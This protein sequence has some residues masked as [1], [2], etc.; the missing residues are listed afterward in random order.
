MSTPRDNNHT[1]SHFIN[2]IE[3]LDFIGTEPKLNFSMKKRNL[4]IWGGLLCI[5]IY[6]LMLIGTLYFGQEFPNRYKPNIVQKQE[7]NLGDTPITYGDDS[8]V[9]LYK[10]LDINNKVIEVSNYLDVVVTLKHQSRA[11]SSIDNE[12]DLTPVS[13]KEESLS[14][15]KCSFTKF[16]VYSS[17]LFKNL[18]ESNWNCIDNSQISG[19]MMS[20]DY[21]YLQFDVNRCN[22][23]TCA[24]DIDTVLNGMTIV[25]KYINYIFDE[26]SYQEVGTKYLDEYVTKL[27]TNQQRNVRF[28]LTVQ[29]YMTDTGYVLEDF[30]LT[31]HFN[32]ETV[33]ETT[34]YYP[35]SP[36]LVDVIFSQSKFKK[37]FYRKYYKVQNLL[38]EMGGLL[39]TF[40]LAS[41]LFNYLHD[42]AKYY[43]VMLNEL[44][45]A[46]DLYK[47]FQYYNSNNKQIFK[48]YR[49][50]ILLKN[51]KAFDYVKSGKERGASAVQFKN[52]FLT[53]NFS[54]LNTR[55]VVKNRSNTHSP[56]S[57]EII[58]EEA[59]HVSPHNGSNLTE[60]NEYVEKL[61]KDLIVREH[62]DKVKRRK[63]KLNAWEM[64]QFML[65]TKKSEKSVKKLVVD[66]GKEIID[67]RTNIIYIIKKMLEFDRFKNLILT[68]NQMTLLDSL[69][70]FMLDPERINLIDFDKCTY[71]KLL[72]A[73]ATTVN[74]NTVLDINLCNWVKNKFHF[75]LEHSE[76]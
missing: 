18:K 33:K 62:F 64:L 71:D 31:N 14:T 12:N 26:R 58:E 72:D 25:I 34:Y 52:N 60:T 50:S 5:G 37:T 21:Q 6:I 75:E 11:T 42:N 29:N 2:F 46:D 23:P 55:A 48:K 70:R 54:R 30:W 73:Y 13:Y 43:E 51:T 28:G 63:I 76:I 41:L 27:N 7:I 24:S 15:S 40:V 10:F 20:N 44:F 74:S 1:N 38:A 67:Q 19:H 57:N 32:I 53:E 35:Y 59:K 36:T 8:F 16:P 56:F 65:C 66:S 49:D 4:T 39:K 17:N 3:S 69:S 9:I 68:S 45:D 47:Y 61:R 22:K